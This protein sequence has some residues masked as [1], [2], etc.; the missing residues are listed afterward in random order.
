MTNADGEVEGG[1][2]LA[3]HPMTG[4]LWAVLHIAGQG[5]TLVTL[6]PVTGASSSIGV[7]ADRVAGIAFDSS[8]TLYGVTGDGAD[9]PETMYTIDPTDASMTFF[10]TLG[11]GFDGETIG[12]NPDDGLMYHA[13]GISPGE[14][15]WESIDLGIPAVV[16]STI[17]D[18]EPPE[19]VLAFTYA[20]NGIF[21]MT[22][23]ISG[24]DSGF[25]TMTTDGTPTFLGAMD[26]SSKGLS[27]F[28]QCPWDLDGDGGVNVL[29]LLE[30]LGQWGPCEP[31]CTAD[32][33]GDGQVGTSDLIKLILNF[34][35]CPGLTA[36]CP[37]DLN[38]DGTVDTLDMQEVMNNLGPCDDPDDCP[39][40]FNGDVTV[41][42]ADINEL[43][44]N[45]G[46][47]P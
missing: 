23:R 14:K 3:T 42:F 11:A 15:V 10:L 31:G 1:N 20:G 29:D 30:L 38:G 12:Y 24:N 47:C 8:G 7:L 35:P 9:I 40:D 19:E 25:F 22:D 6:D 34:G 46:D 21:L 32:F 36:Q 45:L 16:S 43:L 4:E 33:D 13:S 27:F 18:Q 26:H 41:D 44:A 28:A 39:W 5:R 2:G 17:V 37:W